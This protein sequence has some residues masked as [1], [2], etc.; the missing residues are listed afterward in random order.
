M[1]HFPTYPQ[2]W[3]PRAGFC[4]SQLFGCGAFLGTPTPSVL[5]WGWLPCRL[6]GDPGACS[7]LRVLLQTRIST[8]TAARL[9]SQ[10]F[11][12]EGFPW[13]GSPPK[14]N[15]QYPKI[16]ARRGEP[17]CSVRTLQLLDLLHGGKA[18]ILKILIKNP[19]ASRCKC[20]ELF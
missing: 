9:K 7:T 6:G 5:A 11:P 2:I 18:L 13:E 12:W 1:D 15:E 3:G 16:P 20:I 4:C 8:G 17:A 19:K 14:G 10:G